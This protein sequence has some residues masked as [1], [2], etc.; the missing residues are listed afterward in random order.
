MLSIIFIGFKVAIWRGDSLV[1][2]ELCSSKRVSLDDQE[3][4]GSRKFCQRGTYFG[5]LADYGREDQNTNKSGTPSACKWRFAG[6]S[7]KAL[8]CDF[9]RI[10][11][12]VLLETPIAL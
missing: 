7:M 3:I 11:G 5:F 10:S 12:P 6:W 9:F 8:H 2:S 1:Y 4:R